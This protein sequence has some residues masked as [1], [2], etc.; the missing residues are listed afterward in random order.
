MHPMNMAESEGLIVNR[1]RELVP[2]M[3]VGGME[4][5]EADGLPRMGASFGGMLAS[6]VKAAKEALKVYDSLDHEDGEV[7]G[8]KGY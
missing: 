8:L 5:S 1:T 2:G 4:L 7:R 3:I 6:G